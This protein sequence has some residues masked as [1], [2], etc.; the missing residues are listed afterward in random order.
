MKPFLTYSRLFLGICKSLH[1]IPCSVVGV[2][3]PMMVFMPMA[4]RT[5]PADYF[6]T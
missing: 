2:L 5:L 3:G 1:A 4:F 6:V